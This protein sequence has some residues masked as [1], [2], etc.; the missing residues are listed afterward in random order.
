MR[1]LLAAALLAVLS[2]AAD[3]AVTQ[4]GPGAFAGDTALGFDELPDGAVL[5][6]QYAALQL[7]FD[8]GSAPFTARSY[9]AQGTRLVDTCSA[10][11]LGATGLR[12]D[13]AGGSI[14]FDVPV[15]RVGFH[16]GSSR[17]I[18]VPVLVDGEGSATLFFLTVDANEMAFFAFDDPAGIAGIVFDEELIG[19]WSVFVDG[20]R[21]E[22]DP[23]GFVERVKESAFPPG[24]PI[25][26]EEYPAGEVIDDQ[27]A[28]DGVRF[29]SSAGE[30]KVAAY[31]GSGPALRTA[32]GTH[33]CGAKAV[34]YES[35]FETIAFDPPVSQVGF[36]FGATRHVRVPIA[37]RRGGA[38]SGSYT[39]V[40]PRGQLG[41]FGF[42]DPRGI[43]QIVFGPEEVGGEDALL[44]A[45]RVVPEPAGATGAACAALAVLAALGRRARAPRRPEASRR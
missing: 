44:D 24:E 36:R 7:R 29:A 10:L 3:A 38:V 30:W 21:F 33:G 31:G 5:D 15:R 40:V 19:G 45:L 42:A 1:A 22:R 39:M 37:F 35:R 9:A 8:E 12:L 32:S 34:R 11:G 20:L 41:F 28:G 4:V 14:T 17:P 23:G 16:L 13:D 2:A 26:F 6:D 43:E 18:E 27:L 25:G